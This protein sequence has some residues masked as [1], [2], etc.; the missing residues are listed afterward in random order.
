MDIK[1]LNYFIQ[2]A[3]DE[4]YSTA[5]KKLYISQPAL[6]KVVKNLE[7]ELNMKLFYSSE[8]KT[9]LTDEGRAFFEKAQKLVEDFNHLL[10]STGKS[11]KTEKGFLSLGL[12]PIVG[13][14]FLSE[15]VIE[16]QKEYPNID[17]SISEKGANSIQQD[18][19][20]GTMDIGC[21]I[22]PIYSN[23]FEIIPIIHDRNMVLVNENHP[24]AS[25]EKLTV[26]DLI[27]ENLVI[28]S[29]EFTLN[30]QIMAACKEVGFKPNVAVTSTQWDFLTELV[31]LNF[32][33]SIL[34][35]PILEK[36]PHPHSVAVEFDESESLRD[37]NP[38][39][40]YRKNRYMSNAAKLFISF[41][42]QKL[43]V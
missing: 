31:A 19:F 36:Y 42:K 8:R 22:T 26:S 16:F 7:Q 35:R 41:L 40:I 6:S 9:K 33:I 39:L 24:F 28:F 12:M 4:S 11:D 23:Q 25:K 13:S 17:I 21:A 1:Q 27:D 10:E 34:P 14:C 2:I 5:S 29:E 37:W 38:A 43:K 20:L 15:I 3:N 30:Q 18:V 32:G